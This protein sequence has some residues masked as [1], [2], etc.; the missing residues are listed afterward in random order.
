MASTLFVAGLPIQLASSQCC[1]DNVLATSGGATPLPSNCG[2]VSWSSFPKVE[3]GLSAGNSVCSHAERDSLGVDVW[4]GLHRPE[5]QGNHCMSSRRCVR[6]AQL[7][8]MPSG[9]CSWKWRTE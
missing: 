7:C 1:G 8:V 5:E 9:V 4:N 6:I 2:K 3:R